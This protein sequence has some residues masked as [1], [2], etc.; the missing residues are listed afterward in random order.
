MKTKV[1]FGFNY[2]K[3]TQAL[4]HFALK[5]GGKI[6]KMKALKLIYFADRYHLRKYGRLITN[7]NYV[8]MDNGAVPSSTRD[9]L[10]MTG[11]IGDSEKDYANRYIATKGYDLK[12]SA[13]PDDDVFSLSDIEAIE[14]AW[15]QFGHLG[16]YALARLTHKYPEWDIHK[17]ALKHKPQSSFPM[18]I[19]NFLDDPS[20]N[21]DKCFELSSAD[22]NLRLEHLK[23]TAYIESIW[24]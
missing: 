8:A 18:N 17:E 4:N 22:K 9:I 21:V 23:E 16:G 1:A 20:S 6:N 12:S 2:R 14:F 3:A 19:D 15:K 24:S 5:Q 11:F 7:D 10:E 13:S